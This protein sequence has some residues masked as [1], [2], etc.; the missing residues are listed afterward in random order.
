MVAKFQH[1]KKLYKF[2]ISN[3]FP[4]RYLGFE[5]RFKGV[6]GLLRVYELYILG[7]SDKIFIWIWPHYLWFAWFTVNFSL[8]LCDCQQSP[9]GFSQVF[10]VC[11]VDYG[12]LSFNSFSYLNYCWWNRNPRTW[13]LEKKTKV[14]VFWEDLTHWQNLHLSF[15]ANKVHIFWEGHKILQ[16]L[17]LTF[18]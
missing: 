6:C 7:Q 8:E 4:P 2:Y 10:A 9:A 3:F 16:N 1:V 17:H 15:D 18:D 13:N 11:L 12:H 14:H 5:C